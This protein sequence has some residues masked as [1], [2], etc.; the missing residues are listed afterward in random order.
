MVKHYLGCFDHTLVVVF[1]YT[2]YLKKITSLIEALQI[3]SVVTLFKILV[4]CSQFAATIGPSC[5]YMLSP[6]CLV[7]C[8]RP[9]AP[10]I[11]LVTLIV[12]WN[13]VQ[14]GGPDYPND[15]HIS[16]PI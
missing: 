8:V 3:K 13:A 4:F 2:V 7:L 16:S 1:T 14:L 5:H 12:P 9:V 11:L 15:L 6:V 10:A